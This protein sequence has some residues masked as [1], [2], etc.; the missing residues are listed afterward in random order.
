MSPSRITLWFLPILLLIGVTISHR[1]LAATEPV[2]F[3]GINLNG[4]ATR[5][6]G[7]DWE[8][9]STTNLVLSGKSFENQQVPLRPATDPSRSRMIRSSRWGSRVDVSLTSVP[10]GTFQVFAYVWEDNH[11]EQ[12]DLLLNGRVVA[13]KFHSGAAGSWQR[14]GPWPLRLEGTNTQITLSARGPGHGAANLSGIEVW[15][16]AGTIPSPEAPRFAGTPSAD[17]VAFFESRI[18]PVLVGHCYECHSAQSAKLKGGLLLDSWAGVIRGGDSGPIIA[19]GDPEA[20]LLIRAVQRTDPALTM[21]PKQSLPPQ[22]IED[23]IAWVRMGAPDPRTED[24]VAQQGA[25]SSIDWNRAREWWSFRPVVD[26]PLPRLRNPSW[27]AN[28]LDTFILAR[29]ESAGLGPTPDADRRTLIRR[30]SFDLLGLPPDPAEVDAFVHDPSP[31]AVSRVVDRFLDSPRYGERWGRHWLDVV[32]YADTAGD[33]SDFPVPQLHQYRDWVIRSFNQ[34]LSFHQ[35]VREQIAGDLLENTDP[36]QRFS[37]IIAT[38]YL[39]NARRFGSRVDDY[40]WHLTIEDT[41]DNLGRSFLGLSLNCARCHDHKFDPIPTADYYALY[42]IFNSTRYPW[43]GIELEQRQRD[44]I[45]LV[46]PETLPEY[47]TRMSAR[48][49]EREQLQKRLEQARASLKSSPAS[50]KAQAEKHVRDAE[51][52]LQDHSRQA[53]LARTA[54]AVTESQRTGDAVIQIKGDPARPGATVPRRFLQVL[55]G[56]PLPAGATGSGRRELAGWITDRG[57]PLIDRVWVN[58]VWQHHFGRGLVP[59]PNDFGR[60]GR[61]PSH[62]ELLD[63]LATRFQESDGSTKALHRMIL[64]SRTYRQGSHRTPAS[65]EKDPANELLGSFPRRRLDAEALRDT[66]L[67]L[68]ESLD[69]SPAG[70]HPFPPESEWKFTQHHPFRALYESSHRSVFLMTQRIQRHPFLAVFDGAD[71]STSTAARLTSTTPV[72]ALFLLNDPLVHAQAERFGRRILRS[73]GTHAE[74]IGRAYLW[75]LSRW[76]DAQEVSMAEGFLKEA[77]TRDGGADPEH[78]AAWNSLARALMRL[79]EFVYLD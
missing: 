17:Q 11:S 10:P 69:L 43:P 65:V 48:R 5:I 37:R 6:D 76:P 67:L 77:M 24:T 53:P 1:G 35:F 71:P 49:T 33:N 20:S 57:N 16:G 59:S 28:G 21:P 64:L 62:P 42:G 61:P 15:S 27:P 19:P 31:D 14:L 22:A 41:L 2:F 26:P 60:Q 40:P 3:R 74:R 13:E 34:D 72:Q 7:H 68:G 78:P 55:G 51:Q 66:L 73:G 50:E 56:A 70:A 8:A 46:T 75:A 54:Y 30:M 63:W 52:A 38:G 44:L 79:N 36:E 18:R 9:E 47:H 29:L 12:F 58:R 32:R 39:A 45:Q 23:L 25:R 4:P